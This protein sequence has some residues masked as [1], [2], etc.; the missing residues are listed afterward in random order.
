M[1]SKV[2]N[3]FVN[4]TVQYKVI[5]DGYKTVTNNI[6]VTESFPIS[7]TYNLEASD[8]VHN[9]Q[10]SYT[11]NTNVNSQPI[12]TFNNSLVT[13]D[14]TEI[15]PK[16][17]VL[18]PYGI[19]YII[20]KPED[21][22][23]RIGNLTITEDYIA[24]NFTTSNYLKLNNIFNPGSSI[25]KMQFKFKQYALD[26]NWRALFGSYSSDFTSG[27]HLFLSQSGK[28]AVELTSTNGSWNIADIASND[29]VFTANEWYWVQ[30]EFTGSDY[31]A[32]ISDDGINFTKIIGVTT[33]TPINATKTQTIGIDQY[34]NSDTQLLNGELDLKEC[35]IKI[36]NE[37][38]WKPFVIMPGIFD[39]E[40]ED[41]GSQT[42][43]NLYDMETNTREL[44]LNND[45][46]IHVNNKFVEYNGDVDIP[47]HDLA[48][49]NQSTTSW[50]KNTFAY[51]YITNIENADILNFKDSNIINNIHDIHKF[52]NPQVC[53][54]PIDGGE[55]L[56]EYEQNGNLIGGVTFDKNTGVLS[57]FSTSNYLSLPSSFSPGT[58]TWE[59]QI[60]FTTGE[61]P[62]STGQGLFGSI[63]SSDGCTP[64]YIHGNGSNSTLGVFLSSNGTSWDLTGTT[65]T[66][67]PLAENTT[68]K[69]KAEFTGTEYNWYSWENDD[70]VL[71]YTLTSSTAVYSGLN[72]LI[73]NNRAQNNPFLGT[74]DLSQSYIKINNQIWWSGIKS[75]T[76]LTHQYINLFH[77]PSNCT[78]VGNINIDSY[79]I[80][81]GFSDVNYIKVQNSMAFG[82]YDY[83]IICKFKIKDSISNK[84]ENLIRTEQGFLLGIQNTDKTGYIT[85]FYTNSYNSDGH[86]QTYTTGTTELLLNTWYYVKVT[87]INN[88][89]RVYLS[90]DKINWYLE[91]TTSD[92]YYYSLATDLFFGSSLGGSSNLTDADIDLT[93]CKIV[94][95]GNVI[96]DEN[97]S[98]HL[99]GCFYDYIDNGGEQTFDVYYDSSYKQ[100]ILV[101][102]GTSY[103]SGTKF[104]TLT[105][106]AHQAWNYSSGGIW[107]VK[108]T[109][110]PI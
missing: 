60:K 95:D 52:E 74:V 40:Y 84:S 44:I 54:M 88:V 78:I 87:R 81:S 97:E 14:N 33:P 22:Y 35:W 105:I 17:Y 46:N 21:V 98:T 45:R 100:P 41:T 68:Y 70:W 96:L 23:T 47:D 80:A 28:I 62:S 83:E 6:N 93:E 7:T 107:D 71:K 82:I 86:W 43:L 57:N 75:T 49:Y 16:S 27:A 56:I 26:N 1:T 15:L 18:A 79:G 59:F 4:S 85:K 58:N 31:N 38:W 29:Q 50:V 63:G 102:S 32:Y 20:D 30:L 90:T 110:I 104:G 24:K 72:M 3:A 12:I 51:N 89:R 67:M 77:L 108:T 8:V 34:M 73:G 2:I 99:S 109:R 10:I 94:L 64:F 5:K 91:S 55:T 39:S 9:P 65:T 19:N 92:G 11:I 76:E 53:L 13:P 36:N 61:L 48:I 69:L 37:Y 66:V 101:E 106:P 42:T 25:W 103:S